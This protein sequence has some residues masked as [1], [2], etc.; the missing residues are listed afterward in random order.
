MYRVTNFD[1]RILV[2]VKRYPSIAEVP[3]KVTVDCLLTARSKA[4]IKTC[5]YMIVVTIIGCIIAAFL[6]K[7]QAERGENLFKMRQD[8]YEEMLEKDKNK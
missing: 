5:N 2:W 7:R 4:R 6:G 1:K 3:E 8:W